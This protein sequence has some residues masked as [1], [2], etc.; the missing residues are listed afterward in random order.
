[1]SKEQ[2]CGTCKWHSPQDGDGFTDWFCVNPDSEYCTDYTPYE[3]SCDE[4]EERE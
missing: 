2:C 1:M 3:H 4:W